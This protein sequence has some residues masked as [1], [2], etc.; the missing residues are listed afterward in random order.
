[1]RTAR[2]RPALLFQESLKLQPI[3]K[4]RYLSAGDPMA[5]PLLRNSEEPCK[6]GLFSISGLFGPGFKLRY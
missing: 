2:L 6:F 1:M 3:P 4:V 5:D